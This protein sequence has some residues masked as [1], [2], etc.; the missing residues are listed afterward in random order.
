MLRRLTFAA[1]LAS[2]LGSCTLLNLDGFE[3]PNCRIEATARGLEP[4]ELCAL[5]LNEQNGFPPA[6]SCRPYLCNEQG[7]CVVANEER[8]EGHDNDCD[9][10]VDE[11]LQELFSPTEVQM[12]MHFAR[13]GHTGNDLASVSVAPGLADVTVTFT[14]VDDDAWSFALGDRAEDFIYG[15][16]E[17]NQPWP[18][19]TESLTEDRCWRQSFPGAGTGAGGAPE[20]ASTNCSF[21]SIATDR[22]Q[23]VGLIAAINTRAGCVDGQLRVGHTT[24]EE[25]DIFQEIGRAHV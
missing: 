12:D 10:L 13:T 20:F 4:D 1:A 7:N 11:D 23:G 17:I 14:D 16:N 15:H 21:A 19:T 18:R 2:T 24:A 5:A 22:V 3:L 8:C 25:P 9:G 6:D